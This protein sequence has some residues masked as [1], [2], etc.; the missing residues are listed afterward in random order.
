M[1]TYTKVLILLDNYFKGLN[2]KSLFLFGG[3]YWFA[4]YLHGRIPGSIIVI[5]RVHEHCAIQ[6]GG[7]TYDVTG[8]VSNKNYHKASDREL[9]FMKKNYIPKGFDENHLKKYLDSNLM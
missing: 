1:D 4:N 9:S 7:K 6:I 2:W 3:C 8:R 5:D